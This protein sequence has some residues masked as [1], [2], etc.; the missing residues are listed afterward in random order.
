MYPDGYPAAVITKRETVSVVDSLESHV[1]RVVQFHPEAPVFG[2]KN[3][4]LFV[5]PLSVSAF[6]K[7]L[8]NL[9]WKEGRGLRVVLVVL[10]GRG[11]VGPATVRLKVTSESVSKA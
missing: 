1:Q 7:M 8:W 11:V 4:R 10:V 2:K 3:G 9:L 6:V 5:S